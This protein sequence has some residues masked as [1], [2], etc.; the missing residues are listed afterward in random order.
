MRLSILFFLCFLSNLTAF[1]Q[2]TICFE[3]NSSG[4]R[5]HRKICVIDPEKK[6][7]ANDTISSISKDGEL[8]IKLFPNPTDLDVNVIV[9]SSKSDHQIF[10]TLGDING[11]I[12]LRDKF[13]IGS[14]VLN[15]GSLSPGM[16]F[17]QVRTNEKVFEWK[18]IKK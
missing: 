7:N 17:L 3:Y 10:Y 13:I 9:T 4:S 14:N 16:Y 1:S 12:L 11:K 18:I 6:T 2:R 8:S 5:E 15:M